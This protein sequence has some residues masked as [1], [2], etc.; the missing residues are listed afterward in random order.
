[1]YYAKTEY[2]FDYGDAKVVR[3]ASDEKGGSIVLGIESSKHKGPDGIQVYVTKTG[4]IRI[5]SAGSEWLPVSVPKN[6]QPE[7][8]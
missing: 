7:G 5:Y 8:E 2:G 3:L 1:M 4:K 6:K